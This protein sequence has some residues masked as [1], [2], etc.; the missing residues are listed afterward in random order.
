MKPDFSSQH[1]RQEGRAGLP[2]A[3]VPLL[4]PGRSASHCSQSGMTLD[5]EEVELPLN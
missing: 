4:L 1:P 5:S 3:A 2:V